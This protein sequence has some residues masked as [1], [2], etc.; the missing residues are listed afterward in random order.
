M[1]VLHDTMLQ[2]QHSKLIQHNQQQIYS[3]SSIFC[4]L[5]LTPYYGGYRVHQSL[6]VLLIFGNHLRG[7]I[8]S[9]KGLH[10]TSCTRAKVSLCTVL[11]LG[12]LASL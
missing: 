9:I 6:R 5:T 3:R 8:L 10:C 12:Q 1:W 4:D 2:D 7:V 11:T